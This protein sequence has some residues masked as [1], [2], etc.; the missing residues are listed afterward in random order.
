[1]PM[2]PRVAGASISAATMAWLVEQMA[3]AAIAIVWRVKRAWMFIVD[4][5]WYRFG[6]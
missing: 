6:A 3:R 5:L 1:M 2:E 4:F